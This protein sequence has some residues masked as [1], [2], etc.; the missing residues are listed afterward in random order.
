[1]ASEDR[2]SP[3]PAPGDTTAAARKA[4]SRTTSRLAACTSA[5]IATAVGTDCRFNAPQGRGRFE[6]RRRR[7]RRRLSNLPRPC[8]GLLVGFERNVRALE[9][10][11]VEDALYLLLR[12]ADFRIFVLSK[13]Y[14]YSCTMEGARDNHGI[15]PCPYL[16]AS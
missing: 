1:M 3:G 10:E 14:M 12:G 11:K 2:T 9:P 13:C 16:K 15:R 4:C 5:T 8:G 7:F 6:R